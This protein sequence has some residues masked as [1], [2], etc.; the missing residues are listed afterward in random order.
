MWLLSFLPS[1][2]FHALTLLGVVGI[3][4]SLLP[5]PY[6]SIVQIVSVVVL[7]FAL[8]MEGGVANEEVWQARV[9]E[10]EAKVAQAEVKSVKENVKIVEKIV[11]KEKIIEE[12]QDA[13]VQYIDREIVKYDNQCKIPAAFIDAHNKAAEQV[14]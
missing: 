6:K 13:I 12:R 10:V 8:Y 4:A 5:I 2:F 14:K 9:L 3:L 11:V 1:Y 7:S